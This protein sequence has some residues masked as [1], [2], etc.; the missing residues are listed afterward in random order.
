MTEEENQSYNKNIDVLKTFM[1]DIECLEELNQWTSRFNIFD[2]LK[3]SR[4]EIRHSNMLA[5]LLDPNESHGLGDAFLRKFLQSYYE[6]GNNKHNDDTLAVFNALLADL[7][8]VNVLREWKNIDLLLYSDEAKFYIAIENKIDSVEHTSGNTEVSQLCKYREI[9]KNE[10]RF[11]GYKRLLIYLTPNGDDP[12]TDEEKKYWD[13]YSY[14]T[15]VS[16]LNDLED[17]GSCNSGAKLLIDNYK[18]TLSKRIVMN[19][20][21]ETICAKIYKKHQ[22]ALDLLFEYRPDDVLLVNQ[23]CKMCMAD[24]IK[25]DSDCEDIIYK[26][27][28]NTGKTYLRFTTKSLQDYTKELFPQGSLSDWNTDFMACGEI[29]FRQIDSKVRVSFSIVVNNPKRTPIN[30]DAFKKLILDKW[31]NGKEIK[32]WSKIWSET[33]KNDITP[34]PDSETCDLDWFKKGVKN[35]IKEIDRLIE[36]H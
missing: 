32:Q 18:E 1:L 31:N 36:R 6:E 19:E 4:T 14:K 34:N 33:E 28:Y 21:I 25:N 35:T 3:I 27:D 2:V 22:A 23:Q 17:F 8:S 30:H 12:I 29:M 26:E 5:W 16:I 24:I 15:I 9:L 20:A 11:K 13:I 7:Y 10:P